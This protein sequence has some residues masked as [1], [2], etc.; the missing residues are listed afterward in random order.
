MVTFALH[1]IIMIGGMLRTASATCRPSFITLRHHASFQKNN[2]LH[3]NGRI[4]T[5]SILHASSPFSSS[6]NIG[7]SAYTTAKTDELKPFTWP[8][9]IDLFRAP[10]DETDKDENYIP[11][12]HPKLELF[13]R[14]LADQASYEQHKNYL[15]TY[16][17]SAYDYLVVSKFGEGFGFEKVMVSEGGITERDENDYNPIKEYCNPNN[18]NNTD[19]IPPIG[20]VWKASPSLTQASKYA[21]ENKLTYLKLVLND[22]PYHVDEGIEHWILWKIGGISSTE[23]ILRQELTW[24]ME[25]LDS[26]QADENS[27]SGCIIDRNQPETSFEPVEA[28]QTSSNGAIPS[29][30]DS[31]FWVNPPHL[32][33][34]PQIHHAHMLVL[35]SNE[36]DNNVDLETQ[37]PPPV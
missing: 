14:S 36:K 33:S 28:S 17:R 35:R 7:N 34:M 31:L 22:Y 27:G 26:L 4:K 2:H 10:D 11:S 15:D 3:A 5:H 25:E 18:S 13:R 24:A 9:L 12:D 6:T 37:H 16:W 20:Y 8:Q 29:P 23:G 32:Q 1:I 21:I 19:I 30:I